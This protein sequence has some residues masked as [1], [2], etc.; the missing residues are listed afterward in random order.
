[1]NK[2]VGVDAIGAKVLQIADPGISASLAS[3]FIHSL[4]SGLIPQEW[5]SANVTPVQKGGV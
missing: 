3:L 5:K 4:E 2:T 1:M